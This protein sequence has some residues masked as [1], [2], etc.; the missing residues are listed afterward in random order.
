MKKIA[1]FFATIFFIIFLITAPSHSAKNMM[2][3]DNPE[4]IC[5]KYESILIILIYGEPPEK[6]SADLVFVIQA[7]EILPDKPGC[8]PFDDTFYGDYEPDQDSAEKQ[9][10]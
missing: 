7:Y 5:K 6:V 4:Q 2:C 8:H 1:I 3:V 9:S 10:I